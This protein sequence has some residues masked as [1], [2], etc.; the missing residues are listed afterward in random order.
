[1]S[2]ALDIQRAGALLQ[3]TRGPLTIS[4][5]AAVCPAALA[6]RFEDD[7]AHEEFEAWVGAA[8]P[9]VLVAS[10]PLLAQAAKQLQSGLEIAWLEHLQQLAA[11]LGG[12]QSSQGGAP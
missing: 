9:R 8:L 4:L 5:S 10:E 7:S 2:A 1:M 6:R 12:D 11:Q 3:V